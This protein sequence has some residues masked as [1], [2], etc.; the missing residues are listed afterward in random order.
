MRLQFLHQVLN[1]DSADGKLM[2]LAVNKATDYAVEA[3]CNLP[4]TTEQVIQCTRSQY[5]RAIAGVLLHDVDMY[6]ADFVAGTVQN[7][8]T[9]ARYQVTLSQNESHALAVLAA[10]GEGDVAMLQLLLS[11]AR[12]DPPPG[13]VG[14]VLPSPLALAIRGQHTCA[15]KMLLA[16][17]DSHRDVDC[18]DAPGAHGE[19]P[20]HEAARTGSIP[21]VELFVSRADGVNANATTR[22]RTKHGMTPLDIAASAGH[23]DL[24]KY[25]FGLPQTCKTGGGRV[26]GGGGVGGKN[27]IYYAVEAQNIEMIEFLLAQPETIITAANPL[28]SPLSIAASLARLDI[29]KLLDTKGRV[30]SETELEIIYHGCLLTSICKEDMPM[31]DY[32][33]G[34][35]GVPLGR[36]IDD[37]TS[38]LAAAV[39]KGQDEMF[40]KLVVREE[41]DPTAR[42]SAFMQAVW[43]GKLGIAQRLIDVG[44]LDLESAH[45]IRA[46]AIQHVRGRVEVFEFLKR[47]GIVGPDAQMP[48]W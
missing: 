35:P 38:L 36:W 4:N 34:K 44:N 20:V 26:H 33:F 47:T 19:Y 9:R 43:L 42:R 27:T 7:R 48:D 21:L 10:A 37:Y 25:L 46:D 5:T 29:I 24:V 14:A 3:K 18:P 40:E 8:A 45:R 39:Q 28:D 23:V 41:F 17:W 13:L 2:V 6:Y 30:A 32:F 11:P 12:F 16:R 15:V 31:F 1:R 22:T